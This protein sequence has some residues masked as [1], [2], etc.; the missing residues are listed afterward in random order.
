[1]APEFETQTAPVEAANRNT[2]PAIFW[3]GRA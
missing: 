2:S 3:A 1:V